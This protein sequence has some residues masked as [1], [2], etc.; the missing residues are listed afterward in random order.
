MQPLFGLRKFFFCKPIT[1]EI[2]YRPI[3]NFIKRFLREKKT[4]DVFM[5]VRPSYAFYLCSCYHVCMFP[6]YQISN[7]FSSTQL[8]GIIPRFNVTVDSP[9]MRMQCKVLEWILREVDEKNVFHWVTGTRSLW[10]HKKL[11][12]AET[13]IYRWTLFKKIGTHEKPS[14]ILKLK[15]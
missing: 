1:A 15:I 11:I 9:N 3:L 13:S 7:A 8:H 5:K 14:R 4:Q 10:R 12:F 2:H 6:R